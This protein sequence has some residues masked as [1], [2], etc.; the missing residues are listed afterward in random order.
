MQVKQSVVFAAALVL[1]LMSAPLF[2]QTG[3]KPAGRPAKIVTKPAEQSEAR[4]HDGTEKGRAKGK[5]KG[6]AKGK[7]KG[8]AVGHT[9]SPNTQTSKP[10]SKPTK[11]TPVA[12]TQE[13]TAPRVLTEEEKAAAKTKKAGKM[14]GKG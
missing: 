2:A 4:V 10:S 11:T 5:A 3:T 14:G 7:A 8:K 12:P 1:S 9:A 13:V 6:H